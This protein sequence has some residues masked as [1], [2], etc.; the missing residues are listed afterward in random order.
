MITSAPAIGRLSGS[1]TVPS[2][3]ATPAP[4]WAATIAGVTR[5]IDTAHA[6]ARAAALARPPP[7][8]AANIE[9]GI[10]TLSSSWST[11]DYRAVFRSSRTTR[12]NFTGTPLTVAGRYFQ[13]F[14]VAIASR[15]YTGLTGTVMVTVSTSP[16]SLITTV[17]TPVR[18][19][20][21]SPSAAHD[22]RTTTGGTT[23]E[24][25]ML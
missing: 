4:A 19:A 18:T 24:S 7:T 10:L 5:I 21:T 13:F 11:V 25:C 3:A 2:I 1:V 8:R 6:S 20:N 23:S 14:A 9:M 16:T 15:S 12:R 22:S 17:T